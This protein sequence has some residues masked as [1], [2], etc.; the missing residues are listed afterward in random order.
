MFDMVIEKGLAVAEAARRCG[1]KE[2]T[3]QGLVQRYNEDPEGRLPLPKADTGGRP[4]KLLEEHS[5]FLTNFYD[6]RSSAT[7]E[8]AR[9]ALLAEF[10]EL[11]ISI[12]GLHKHLKEKLRLT[13]KKLERIPAE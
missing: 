2:R 3:A 10:E 7:L 6:E 12:S 8:E 4:S 13:L 11:D 1:I 5:R 9:T